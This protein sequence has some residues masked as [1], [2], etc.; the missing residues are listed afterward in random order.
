MQDGYGGPDTG[1]TG[2]NG[3]SEL[4]AAQEGEAAGDYAD[5]YS[6]QED[7]RAAYGHEGAG[8]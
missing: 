4:R 3:T 1:Q 7:E 8:S 6:C 5:D 2:Q